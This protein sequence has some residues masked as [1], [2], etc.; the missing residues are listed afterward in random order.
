MKSHRRSAVLAV[1]CAAVIGLALGGCASASSTTTGSMSTSPSQSTQTQASYSKMPM[2]ASASASATMDK[3]D[4]DC[5]PCMSKGKVPAVSGTV[6]V[7]DGVQVL[8]IGIKDNAYSPNTFSAKS[9][10]PIKV[11][12]T[13]KA[14]DCLAK[15]T[16]PKLNKSVDISTTG[17]GTMEL[18]ALQPGTYELTCGMH[19]HGGNLVVQ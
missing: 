12:F 2:S 17:Q 1:A 8:E 5:A 9:G 19:S 15:P 10:M 13:G 14:S 11:V 6:K 18:G 3:S 4:M 7:V 16:F